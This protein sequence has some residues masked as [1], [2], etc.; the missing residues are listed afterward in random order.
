MPI[1]PASP[2]QPTP[3]YTA[4]PQ[5]AASAP[6]APAPAAG[7]SRTA[8]RFDTGPRNP[9]SWWAGRPLSEAKNAHR[10][11]TREDFEA[12]LAHGYNF[13][14]GDVRVEL[15]APHA[16]EMRHDAGDEAGDNL[17]LAQ[18]LERGAASGR[19]LK[20]DVKETDRMP[21]LL[22]A[23][24]ASGVPKGRLMINLGDAAMR[25]WGPLIRERLPGATL[26]LNPP[27]G[28]L[29]GQLTASQV[30]AMASLARALGG[31]VTFVVRMDLLTDAAVRALSPQGPVSVWNDPGRPTPVD[32][33]K[34]ERELRAR[35]VT[36]VVDLRPGKSASTKA[37]DGATGLL[38][39]V[40]G[41]LKRLA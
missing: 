35:G 8:D 29:N 2:S 32:L 11:N 40:R 4:G 26:A 34:A 33:G 21:E 9:L 30:E 41:W 28:E 16:L 20:L 27:P 31:P 36:G 12:A 25:R 3:A 38:D 6:P 39:R 19:G 23:V 14:E 17:T 37:W 5:G 18:W 7:T 1:R 15:K 13:L 10:T 22:D 24:A